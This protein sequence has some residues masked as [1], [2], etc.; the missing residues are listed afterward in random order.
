MARCV[1][2]PSWASCG[3]G[4]ETL[5]RGNL[6]LQRA[7][8]LDRQADQDSPPYLYD[9]AAT[10]AAQR[11]QQAAL[12]ALRASLSVGWLDFRSLRADPRFDELRSND[13]FR[14]ITTEMEAKVA[15]LREEAR[16]AESTRVRLEDYPTGPAEAAR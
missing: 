4:G 8:G 15:A 13:E 3:C 11:N 10:L 9:L 12:T 7:A 6:L 2:P 14:Q 1:T 5:P 16:R